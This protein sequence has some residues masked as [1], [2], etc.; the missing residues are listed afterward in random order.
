MNLEIVLYTDHKQGKLVAFQNDKKVGYLTYAMKNCSIVNITDLTLIK[1]YEQQNIE[2]ELIDSIAELARNN[3]KQII[4][5]SKFAKLLL[6]MD[7]SYQDVLNPK[8]I[9]QVLA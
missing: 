1:G 9:N 6:E 3:R 5:E 2:K 8:E 7:K 4:A